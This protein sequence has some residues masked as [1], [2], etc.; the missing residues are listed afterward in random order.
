MSKN[1]LQGKKYLIEFQASRENHV[2]PMR[3]YDKHGNLKDTLSSSQCA[4]HS[5]DQ[6]FK[7]YD[8]PRMGISGHFGAAQRQK[9]TQSD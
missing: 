9:E 7:E 6:A 4:Q 2:Y 5:W 3:I 8:D 1:V